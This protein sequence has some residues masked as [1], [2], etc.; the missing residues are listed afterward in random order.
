MNPKIAQALEVL[1]NLRSVKG[2]RQA[3]L[4]A[5]IM[6]LT[7]Q[8]VDQQLVFVQLAECIAIPIGTVKSLCEE[9]LSKNAMVI[10]AVIN[11]IARDYA[12][13]DKAEL[14]QSLKHMTRLLIEGLRAE[15]MR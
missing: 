8:A 9:T 5:V 1:D 11:L 2:E 6:L 4:A 3:E 7:R 12:D 10:H 13:S 15:V 14:E